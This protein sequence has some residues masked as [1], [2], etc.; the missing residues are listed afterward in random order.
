MNGGGCDWWTQKS[1]S[2]L[3]LLRYGVD[4]MPFSD[5]C[6]RGTTSLAEKTEVVCLTAIQLFLRRILYEIWQSA[7]FSCHTCRAFFGPIW[8]SFERA[9]AVDNG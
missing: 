1:K 3:G 2:R 5:T 6:D 4:M 7:N 8:K 9:H